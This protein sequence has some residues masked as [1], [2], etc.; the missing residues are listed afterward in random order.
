MF[1]D[2]SRVHLITTN[3]LEG[4]PDLIMEIVSPDSES[5]DWREKYLEYE[6]AGV[7][8]YWVVD[9]M[10]QHVEAY[11]LSGDGKYAQIMEQDE[12]IASSVVA[13]WYLRPKWLFGEKRANVLDALG[14]LGVR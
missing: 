3:H 7:R 4:A 8:E 2:K 6:A 9:P 1:V 12:R 11:A 10:S 14:E 5:R 13:G